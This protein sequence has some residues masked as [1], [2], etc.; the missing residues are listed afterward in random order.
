[1]ST[2]AI[3]KPARAAAYPRREEIANFASHGLGALLSSSAAVLLVARA[4]QYGDRMAVLGYLLFGL[5]LVLLFT[6]STIYHAAERPEAKRRLRVLDH[7]SI[8]V[9]IAGTYS[10]FCLQA[11]RGALGWVIFGI[12]WT[13][14]VLG[15]VLAVFFTGRFK[16]LSLVGYVA[17]GWIIVLA[18][19]P[20]Q[21]ALP[22]QALVFLIGGG[23]LYT[24]GAAVYAIKRI[25]WN[26]PL[27]HC[28]VLG[29]A[30]CHVVA[31]LSAF[32][33]PV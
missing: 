15:I 28:F 30:A 17:M 26:H 20:L 13:L 25:P 10:A 32:R 5:S 24:L 1:M 7:A 14:A 23:M 11:L 33:P 8:Y 9:L 19:G 21:K 3:T 31:A 16:V 12:V 29:G 22:A 2:T 4:S 18:W 6:A 27:W